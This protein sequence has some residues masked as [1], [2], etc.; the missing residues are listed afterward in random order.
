NS[1]QACTWCAQVSYKSE[2]DKKH[3]EFLCKDMLAMEKH[4]SG[5]YD[6]S[7]FEF[8]DTQARNVLNHI[9]KEEQEH[10][11]KLY[12]YMSANGMYN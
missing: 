7:V 2:Q 9:Q 10:G 4:V 8:N 12:K 3:D 6:T 11:D 5:L 1:Q